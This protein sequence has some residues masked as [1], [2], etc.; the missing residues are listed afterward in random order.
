MDYPHSVQGVNLLNGKFTDGNPLLGQP[1]SLD[2]A[3]WA[4]AVTDELLTVIEAADLV[5]AEGDN[6]QLLKAIRTLS[7]GQVQTINATTALT[8]SVRG[9]VL[10]DSAGGNRTLTL[11][12]ANA[13]FGVVELVLRR[14]DVT[15]NTATIAAAGT[16]KI[17]LD[18][19]AQANG[20]ASTELL[21]AGDYLRLRSDGAGKWWCVGQAPLPSSLA[22]GVATYTAAGTFTFTVPAVLRSGRRSARVTAIGGGGGAGRQP[23]G[24]GGGGGGGYGIKRVDLTGVVSVSITVGAG[25]AGAAAGSGDANGSPGGTSSFGA[26]LSATG[27]LGAT[28]WLGGAGGTATGGDFNTSLG[29]GESAA[30]T[31]SIANPKYRGGSGGGPGATTAASGEAGS[32][33]LNAAAPGGGG[34][35]G[36]ENAA[37]GNGAPGAVIVEW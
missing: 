22:S 27:G 10:F 29:P 30:R 5:P 24:G 37:G 6:A 18:T 31:D 2:P 4:N 28:N 32:P 16:D 14:V 7:L 34:S 9:L 11:P 15:A 26:Y 13:A 20:Q 33:G 1:A 12:A 21:F 8:A 19:T 23:S 25:G 3:S 36:N 35:G 17:M